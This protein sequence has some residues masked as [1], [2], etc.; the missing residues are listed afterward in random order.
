MCLLITYLQDKPTWPAATDGLN[1]IK[2]V[3]AAA[4]PA[5]KFSAGLNPAHKTN[6]SA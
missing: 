4:E 1:I 2:P 5:G 3:V 6:H